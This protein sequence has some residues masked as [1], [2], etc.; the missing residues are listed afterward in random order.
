MP[1]LIAFLLCYAQLISLGN[2]FFFSE[3]NVEQW[4]WGRQKVGGEMLGG[5]KGGEDRVGMNFMRED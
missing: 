1:N 2:M 3:R 5:G 4:I